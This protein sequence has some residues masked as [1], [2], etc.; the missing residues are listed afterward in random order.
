MEPKLSA[1]NGLVLQAIGRHALESAF[2]NNVKAIEP[3]NGVPN[4]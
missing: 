3:R 1:S 4:Q 2:V